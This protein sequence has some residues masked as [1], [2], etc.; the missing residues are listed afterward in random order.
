MV[1]LHLI[2]F[3][4]HIFYCYGYS[5]RPESGILKVST[6]SPDAIIS[7]SQSGYGAEI[8]GQGSAS[9]HIAP[10]TYHLAATV[11]GKEFTKTVQVALKQTTSTVIELKKTNVLPS[12]YSVD[13]QNFDRLTDSGITTTQ[14]VT[15]KRQI[16]TFKPSAEHIILSASSVKTA[17]H[18]IAV[19]GA[20]FKITFSLK[21][22]SKLYGAVIS[23]HDL[24]NVKLS[25]TDSATK[26]V[27]FES[28]SNN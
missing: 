9:V 21:I 13:F 11:N 18:N 3:G 23:Y 20:N 5:D 7:V 25:L 2:R 10:G 8:I 28:E 17:P 19:D 16:F 26:S 6:A 14:L 27:V 22:D 12:V 4:L 1:S 24:S 15:L